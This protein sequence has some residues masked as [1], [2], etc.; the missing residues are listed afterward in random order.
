MTSE[1]SP[2]DALD[3]FVAQMDD[4]ERFMFAQALSLMHKAK[5]RAWF[6]RRLHEFDDW[7]RERRGLER[8]LQKARADHP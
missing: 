3:R 5:S 6:T 4:T 2:R 7:Y 8:R 1:E